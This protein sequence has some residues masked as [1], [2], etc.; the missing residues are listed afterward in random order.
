MEAPL[1]TPERNPDPRRAHDARLRAGTFEDALD[2]VL[3]EAARR[4]VTLH[5]L[6]AEYMRKALEFTGG[7][8][9]EAAKIL[10]I[11]RKTLY[12]NDPTRG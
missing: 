1:L 10:G 3:H 8:K 4:G 5:E 7:R 6:S 12:R 2:Q 9:G 11:D